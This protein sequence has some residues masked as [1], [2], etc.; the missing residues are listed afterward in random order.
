MT[1]R[2]ADDEVFDSRGATR[3]TLFLTFGCLAVIAALL[4]YQPYSARP[5]DTRDF[6]EFLPLLKGHDSLVTQFGK[7]TEYYATRGRANL[8]PYVAI[9]VKWN[10]FGW[11]TVGWQMLRF[12][13]MCSVVGMAVLVIRRFGA[14]RAGAMVGASLFIV[15]GSAVDAWVRLTMAEVIG[16]QFLLGGLLIAFE[17]PRARKWW[18]H[19]AALGLTSAALVLAKEMFVA[20]IPLLVVVAVCWQANDTVGVPRLSRRNVVVVVVCSIATIATAIPLGLVAL[21]ASA[22]AYSSTFGAAEGVSW[23][24]PVVWLTGALTPYLVVAWRSPAWALAQLVVF[25]ALL[26]IGRAALLQDTRLRRHYQALFGLLALHVLAGAVLYLPWPV[27]QPFYAMPFMIAP[28]AA[29]GLAATGIERIQPKSRAFSVLIG[30]GWA[31]VLGS[32][33]IQAID[34]RRATD[35]A[36]RFNAEL[37]EVVAAR[38]TTVDSLV[39]ASQRP[40]GGARAWQSYGATIE[41]YGSAL[42]YDMPPAEDEDCA[43][44]QRRRI[45]SGATTLVMRVAKTCAAMSGPDTVIVRRFV[46]FDWDRLRPVDDSLVAEFYRGLGKVEP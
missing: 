4:I 9:V 3:W 19:A 29:V 16:T 2:R 24:R 32:A 45:T 17:L 34:H 38:R 12:L 13:Q 46:Q 8:I 31:F 26:A 33:T 37:V 39:V 44:A 11:H 18:W 42:S 28:A 7:L 6:S 40:L 25:V 15:G 41:R 20:T 1:S 27:Y 10:V 21:H 36:Q 30:L 35:A 23:L 14:S 22:G 43:A 5:I